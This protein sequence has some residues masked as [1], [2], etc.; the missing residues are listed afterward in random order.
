MNPSFVCTWTWP[1]SVDHRKFSLNKRQ[2]PSAKLFLRTGN[3]RRWQGSE[4]MLA[5]SLS[6][7]FDLDSVVC[8]FSLVF[9]NRMIECVWYTM[10]IGRTDRCSCSACSSLLL[11]V[12]HS[13]PYVYDHRRWA[14]R[15][16]YQLC[17]VRLHLFRRRCKQP[18]PMICSYRSERW[19]ML[20]E[21]LALGNHRLRSVSVF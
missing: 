15:V 12:N 9:E 1:N 7:L 3:R 5:I 6:R 4:Q 11:N 10:N 21:C 14:D 2:W 19:P 18:L 20:V 8:S 13:C 16:T 17:L